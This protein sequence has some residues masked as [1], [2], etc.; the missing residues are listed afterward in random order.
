MLMLV[1]RF[2]GFLKSKVRIHHLH[3]QPSKSKAARGFLDSFHGD[4]LQ[5]AED[6]LRPGDPRDPYGMDAA[7]RTRRG[8]PSTD[9]TKQIPFLLH[10][11]GKN[12]DESK[13]C[14][15]VHTCKVCLNTNL[16]IDIC[17]QTAAHRY[18]IYMLHIYIYIAIHTLSLSLY[19]YICILLI[20]M[21]IFMCATFW[22]APFQVMSKD[23]LTQGGG[24]GSAFRR[25]VRCV[26]LGLLGSGRVPFAP[27]RLQ[28]RSSLSRS[29]LQRQGRPGRIFDCLK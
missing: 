4:R 17:L 18:N 13:A 7:D 11:R 3:Q 28:A 1:S 16:Y 12:W 5:G 21:Y 14:A 10:L 19:I 8:A 24:P 20:Y 15:Q 25:I 27:G 22:S 9:S 29:Q 6:A 23:R 26:G 2:N